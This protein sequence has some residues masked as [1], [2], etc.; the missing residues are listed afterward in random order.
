MAVRDG[1]RIKTKRSEPTEGE[2]EL[3]TQRVRAA[4]HRFRVQV[5][6][7]TKSSYT[8]A[9]AAE[10]VGLTIKQEYPIVQVVVYDAEEGT[11]K[12]I[13]LPPE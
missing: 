8:T 1:M 6:R 13:E 7:Q 4:D 2:Q 9:E 12:S 11:R 10:Q 3:F 5:D